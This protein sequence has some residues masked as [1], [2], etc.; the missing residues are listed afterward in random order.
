MPIVY[1]VTPTVAHEC[2]LPVLDG[3]ECDQ[4][5][6]HVY[7]SPRTARWG[8]GTV[9]SCP[10]CTAIW[11]VSRPGDPLGLVCWMRPS[12]RDTKRIR[13]RWIDLEMAKAEPKDADA[14]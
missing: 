12:R 1:E 4:E 13:Q 11:V 7:V 14:R 10:T 5:W 8:S 6:H 2:A 9:W 3:A